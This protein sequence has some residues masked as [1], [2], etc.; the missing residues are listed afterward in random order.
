MQTQTDTQTDTKKTTKPGR[1]G[2]EVNTLVEE[3][4]STQEVRKFRFRLKVKGFVFWGAVE[5]SN[6]ELKVTWPWPKVVRVERKEEQADFEQQALPL[7]E[8]AVTAFDEAKS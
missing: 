4:D 2:I 7:L 6:G 3:K 8:V 1:Y 5:K